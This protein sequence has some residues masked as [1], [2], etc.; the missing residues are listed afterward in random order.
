[1]KTHVFRGSK[2]EIAQSLV[3]LSGTV[4]EAIVFEEEQTEA[5]AQA[6]DDAEDIFAEMCPY[7]VDIEDLDDSRD[8]I[9]MR[10]E[11]E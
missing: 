4:R 3:R 10:M 11:G 2:E 6:P 9:Y 1:M 8:S 5:P 7:M